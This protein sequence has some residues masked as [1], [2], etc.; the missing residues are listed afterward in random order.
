MTSASSKKLKTGDDEV[1]VPSQKATIAN[2]EVPSNTASIV[3]PTASSLKKV[4]QER[5]DSPMRVTPLVVMFQ[6]LLRCQ[7]TPKLGCFHLPYSWNEK[8]LVH[9]QTAHGCYNKE[10]LVQEGT[11]LGKDSI[12]SVNGCD[13]LPKIIRVFQFTNDSCSKNWTGFNSPGVYGGLSCFVFM[14]S[15]P[16]FTAKTFH[17]AIIKSSNSRRSVLAFVFK[18]VLFKSS[19]VFKVCSS[20]GIVNVPG[21]IVTTSRYVVPTGRVKVPAGRY[22]VPTG[23]D[24]VIVSAGRSK[25]IPAGRTILVLMSKG[26]LV[27]LSKPGEEV[28]EES[29]K[30]QKSTEVGGSARFDKKKV[31]CY[32]CSELGHFARECTGKQLDSKA[33][34]SAFK[35]KELGTISCSFSNKPDLDDTQGYLC[36]QDTGDHWALHPG[37][38]SIKLELYNKPK[39]HNVAKIPSFVP[40]AAYVPAGS[41]NPPA[42][43]S[44]GSAFPAGS[45][46]RPASVSASRPHGYYNQLYMDEGRW[47]TAVKTS[48]GCS[49]KIKRPSLA[50]I[51]LIRMKYL[52]IVDS[53][54]QRSMTVPRSHKLLQL[55][56]AL[57]SN[58][59][60]KSPVLLAKS[61]S[62]EVI[63]DPLIHAGTQDDSDS[64]C[65]EQV[66]VVPSF[67][68]NRFSGPKVHEA[69]E[70]VESN[71]DYA[72]ELAS[73]KDKN[74]KPKI[75]AENRVL[76]F[77]KDDSRGT[78][79]TKLKLFLLVVIDPLLAF[80]LVVLIQTA[81]VFLLSAEPIPNL[82]E[83]YFG[84]TV[85]QLSTHLK[86]LSYTHYEG[87][88]HFILITDSWRSH[89]TSSDKKNIE[90]KV[91]KLVPLPD[92]KIAIGTKWILKNKRDARGIV[93]RD[94]ANMLAQGPLSGQGRRALSIMRDIILVTGE[95]EM[96]TMGELTF[97]LGL[98]VK[99]KPDE[100]FI[101]QDKY[102]QDMLKKFDMERKRKLQQPHEALQEP[103]SKEIEPDDTVLMF[104][105]LIRSMIVPSIKKIFKYLKGQPKLGLWY[106]RDS[107][108]VLAAY[109]DSDYAG[110][111][112]DRKS[113]T[114]GCQFLGRRLISWQCKK[115]TIVAT[116]STEAE[117]VAAANCCGQIFIHEGGFSTFQCYSWTS[118]LLFDIKNSYLV[119]LK[120]FSVCKEFLQLNFDGNHMP[121]FSCNASA[122][123]QAAIADEGTGEAAPDVPQTILE[124]IQETRPEP[125]Q[126]QEHLPTPPRPTTSDQI[127]PV[128]EQGHTLDPNIASFSGAHES[129]PDLFHFH[130]CG[131]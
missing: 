91:W 52:G 122:R 63:Q 40:R 14:L 83:T 23:K 131:R 104:M 16:M 97:F 28:N 19:G 103:K 22:V 25:V 74:M 82:L 27:G 12:K 60:E 69:S 84:G 5:V 121:L 112:G 39:L 31:K 17:T 42:S 10:W 89:F 120:C 62:D 85:H 111:H 36:P 45:R 80:L 86:A 125:D 124:T 94:K 88:H 113:T 44:A 130:K 6:N 81:R 72:E 7:V 73:F 30:M 114:G 59:K 102:V 118:C 101:S 109:S 47:G 41:R 79:E 76:W 26:Y 98:Q 1:E 51:I 38:S 127:P 87:E 48:E 4:V 77:F 100:I 21:L 29:K 43:V 107:P 71:S 119:G 15:I 75:Q 67:P 129:D 9:Q 70:M 66:I 56:F 8:W 92:G 68:S 64:E 61:S 96:S 57:K 13:D 33:R 108:F 35:L 95:F 90:E 105:E 93:V 50:M 99:Q 65:D 37:V 117:Y 128:F 24:I 49:W 32:K 106:P 2:V 116:S 11:A 55:Q 123:A 78:F 115:Q 18:I 20:Y 3:Q 126:S 34:Y 53:G 58:L 110:S 54:C 46:N